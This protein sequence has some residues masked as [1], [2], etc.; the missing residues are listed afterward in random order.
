MPRARNIKPA[1]FENEDL[2]SIPALGRLLFIG[3]WTLA[4]REGRLEDRPRRIKAQLFPYEECDAEQYLCQ[5]SE[6][7]FIKRYKSG[8]NFYIQINNFVKHQSPHHS[9]RA[10]VI[11]QPEPTAENLR[12]TPEIYA[13][14]CVEIALNEDSLNPDSLKPDSPIVGEKN[15]LA[16]ESVAPSQKVSEEVVA[17]PAEKKVSKRK[18]G[19]LGLDQLSIDHVQDWLSKKRSEGKYLDYDA[20]YVLEIFRNYCLSTGK[21]YE[22][23][24]AAYRNAFTWDR[25][26]PKAVY[27]SDK[28]QRGLDA[29]TR[30]HMR[31]NNPGF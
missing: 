8:D 16:P 10:S 2:P 4:D 14:G 3:L 27:S 23:Y 1:F 5:L 30:G 17:A 6:R 19:R 29:A 11:P 7:G 12:S 20:G 22:D 18:D 26:G 13:T 28:H 15:S 21:T 24:V 9:E 25:C 31:I